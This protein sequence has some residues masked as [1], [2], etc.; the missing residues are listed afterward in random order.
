LRRPWVIAHHTWLPQGFGA[1]AGAAKRVAA[2]FATNL[3][4]SHAIAESL[5]V[6]SALVAN[7]YLDTV[8]RRQSQ[9]LRD[10]D[11][12]FVGRLVSDKGLDVLLRALALVNQQDP[13]RTLTVVG[14][15]PEEPAMRNLAQ[16]LGVH[17]RVRFV[18]PCAPHHIAELLNRHR[19]LLVPSVWEEP[20]G[21]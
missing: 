9:A 19:V 15:G 2:H 11:L 1:W 14:G 6:R 10:S 8:Y 3:S 21:L 5:P 7:P 12:I 20:F 18:G 17:D 4:V 13:H 16:S